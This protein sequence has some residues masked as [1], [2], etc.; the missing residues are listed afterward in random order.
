MTILFSVYLGPKEWL[1]IAV[2]HFNSMH[3]KRWDSKEICGLKGPA[4]TRPTKKLGQVSRLSIA[5]RVEDGH[6]Q[7]RMRP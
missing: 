2:M 5:F 4:S 1:V 7:V 3:K 6:P